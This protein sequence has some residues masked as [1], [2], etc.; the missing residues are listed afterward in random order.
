MNKITGCFY[1]HGRI[2]LVLCFIISVFA[3]H[4]CNGEFHSEYANLP[5][6]GQ[7]DITIISLN[8]D[9]LFLDAS[10]TSFEGQWYLHD[11]RFIFADYSLIGVREF[12]L[13]GNF[14]ARHIQ[15]GRGTNEWHSPFVS[16]TYSKGDLIGIDGSW[17]IQVFDSLYQR[18][19]SPYT[20]LSDIY[21][22][23]QD[24]NKLLRKPNVE[25]T[26]MYS[27]N[28]DSR[29]L[30]VLGDNLII[31]VVTEHIDYNGYYGSSRKDFWEKS[32]IY[33]MVDYNS[34]KTGNKFGKYPPI[35]QTKNIPAFSIYSF[36]QLKSQL[37]TSF[38][39]DSL[40]YIHDQNGKLIY[41][42]GYDAPGMKRDYPETESFEEFTKVFRDHLKRHSY[43][44]QI[45][46][47][48][49]YIFRCFKRE[50]DLGYGMQIYKDYDLIGEILMKERLVM[51]GVYENVYYGVLPVNYETELFR[52]IRFK[53]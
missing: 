10:S 43:Y 51:L 36:D 23:E 19:Y 12:D 17:I 8:A 11:G 49:P 29:A 20:L 33:L 52:I 45:K 53:L 26:H 4:A 44:T 5:H 1:L 32:Y 50:E 6:K 24:W 9:T 21:Y 37:F 39:A 34:Q 7:K 3:L 27:F 41:S 28:L 46:V 13:N 30:S 22:D 15:K 47:A 35:Y 48:D 42:F 16:I 25:T 18:R 38:A 14:V 40:I 2:T 31:P